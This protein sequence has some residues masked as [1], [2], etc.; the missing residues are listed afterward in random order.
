MKTKSYILLLALIILGLNLSSCASREEGEKVAN[1][2]FEA[3]KA[4][5]YEKAMSLVDPVMIE[6]EGEDNV[7]NILTQKEA[8][9][10]MKSYTK[11]T[12]FKL[13]EQGGRS[14]V[15]FLYI[16]TY[17]DKKLYEYIVLSETDDGYKVISY[18][19]YDEESM[20]D[21]YIEYNEGS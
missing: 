18:A 4:R 8:L 14:M 21:E 12:G 17:E 19:Y 10:E 11:E 9:G 7:M 20:R 15:R 2:F 16:T 1:E 13:M 5:D 6:N 3:L